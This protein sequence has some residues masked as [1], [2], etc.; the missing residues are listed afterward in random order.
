MGI[1]QFALIALSLFYL[2]LA[3]YS[4]IRLIKVFTEKNAIK[5]SIAF[6]FGMLLSALARVITLYLISIRIITPNK[7]DSDENKAL[8]IFIY[9]M[10]IIPDMT[11]LC[12]YLFLIWYFYANFIL[13]HINIANDLRLFSK[14]DEPT[15][16]KKTYLLLY[17]MV[18]SYFVAFLIVCLL[19]FT[20]DI[21]NESLY[22]IYSYFAIF[23]P[24]LFVCYYIFLLIKF[25]GRPYY[26]DNMKHQ[27]R[28]I[29][30]VV[31]IWSIAR[32]VSYNYKICI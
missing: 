23:T 6:Y 17:V 10:I 5:I 9:L 2:V 24:V 30:I 4:I 26:N 29:L 27:V 18:P 13:S 21:N 19:T 31:V 16:S 7:R 22:T 8:N 12:V 20:K 1:L 28:K 25:S 15:L 11:S 14:I 3:I 32:M